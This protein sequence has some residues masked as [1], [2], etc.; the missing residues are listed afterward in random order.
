MG[1]LILDGGRVAAGPAERPAAP[2][3]LVLP[4]GA[5]VLPAFA[6]HHLHLLALAAS[7]RSVDLSTAAS[8][9]DV[10]DLVR[11]ATAVQRAG[12]GGWVRGWGLD[13]SDLAEHRLPTVDELDAVAG[14]TPV[15]V[16]HRTG[17]L[18]VRSS[19]AVGEPPPLPADVLADAVSE[20]SAA[21][22]AAGVV[23]LCD[24]THT[25]DRAALE[26]LGGLPLVQR[27]D[28]M[29]GAD[30]L[31]G[32]RPGEVIGSLRVGPAKIMP[33]RCG[34]DGV[35]TL[36]RE[37]H[38]AG[39]SA[40]VHAVDVDEV[41]AALD[42][43]LGVGDRVEHAALCLPEQVAALAAAGVTVVTQPSFVTERSAKYRAEL[44]AV[45]HAWLY[46]L[47]SLLDAGVAVSGSS[48]APVAAAIPLRQVAAAVL[49]PLGADEQISVA[50]AL[51]LVSDP[52]RIGDPADLVVVDTD[53][54]TVA[55]ERI[56]QIR[57]LATWRDGRLLH[58][59]VAAWPDLARW[60]GSP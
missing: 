52:V 50:E 23:R 11:D 30:R 32:V 46:R 3:V 43:G 9:A 29:V 57:V 19:A 14:T 28:A 26:L 36:V 60:Q 35:A 45:E 47:R 6:D 1:E 24:A 2:E 49:R 20:V 7:R 44:S 56:G 40:A 34:L 13:E 5:V 8:L 55:P 42:G 17:H 51:R 48:D 15:V 21:L 16:H 10:L 4:E 25:N 12:G 31:V 58:G 38:E 41:Q 18:R 27:L 33:P 39:F 22:A 53:P 37:A 59:D 54:L